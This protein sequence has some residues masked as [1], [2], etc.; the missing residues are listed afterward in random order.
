MCDIVWKIVG[1]G[2][3]SLLLEASSPK[4]GNVNRTACFSDMDYRNFLASAS[5]LSRGLYESATKGVALAKGILEPSEVGLG[6]LMHICVKDSLTGLNQKNTIL[7]SI[8]LYVPLTVATA[9]SLAEVPRFS[10]KRIR[11]YSQTIIDHTSVVDATN[12]YRAF[13][14]TRPGGR[15]IK[16][17]SEW[18]DLHRRYDFDN[19]KAIENLVEDNVSLADLF[20]MSSQ[21]DEISNEWSNGFQRILGDVLPYLSKVS[22]QLEDLEEGIVRSFVWLLAQR[23]DGLIVKKAGRKRAKEIQLLA[24][25]TMK[26]WSEEEGSESL[27]VNLD[28]ILRE[29]GNLLNPG[30]TADIV[31]AATFCRLVN[32]TYP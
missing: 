20:K 12:L 16:E 32:M 8:L 26:N 3:L 2:Q 17:D 13:K 5:L 31:S 9:A 30:T 21:V 1:L 24:Q 25:T 28:K 23:P 11:K 14:L 6:E 15:M 18:S 29:E 4:P 27:I 19:P 7:G 10:V 22:T